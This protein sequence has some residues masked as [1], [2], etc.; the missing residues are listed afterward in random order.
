M[1]NGGFTMDMSEGLKDVV[2]YFFNPAA[3]GY[4]GQLSVPIFDDVLQKHFPPTA[5]RLTTGDKR[6]STLNELISTLNTQ[7]P[8]L[9]EI[10]RNGEIIQVTYDPR[11]ED[12]RFEGYGGPRFSS[13]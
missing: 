3:G 13:N 4:S 12:V 7:F 6:Y 8:V 5:V 1:K 10:T 11:K 9:I 2:G